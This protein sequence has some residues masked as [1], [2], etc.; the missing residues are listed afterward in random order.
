M[1][2]PLRLEYPG[3]IYHLTSR[4]DRREAIYE[5]DNDR[6]QWLEILSKACERY[7]WR[8]HAYCLMDNHYHALLETVDGNL[9]KGMRHLNGV[10]TQYFNRQHNRVG[11]VFQGRFKAILV[12]K[13]SYL[14]EL[15][16]YVVLNPIRAHMINNM[17]QWEWSS[18][19]ATIGKAQIPDWLETDWILSHFG[20]QRKRARE[21]YIDFV[22]EG[23]GLPSIWGNLRKQ[24]FLGDEAF[25]DQHQKKIAEK[26]ELDEIPALQKRA[27]SKPISDYQNKYKNES[28]AIK[29]AY[30]SG[31]YTMKE[32]GEHFGKHYTTVSRIV[33]RF[34]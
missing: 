20:R 9:S 8:V 23:V 14:L 5:N 17:D 28:I 3:A 19:R 4:G 34:E 25:V 29:E 13:E 33:K 27:S 32:I 30:L 11:H 6:L 21:R 10:Y 2:R 26:A 18:Y 15:T 16:R 7:N 22:R 31:G 24:V 1:A 12:E